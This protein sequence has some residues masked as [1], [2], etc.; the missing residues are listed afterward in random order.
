M[1]VVCSVKKVKLMPIALQNYADSP[2]A[3]ALDCFAVAP[4][5]LD[6]LPKITK[7]L[8]I[9]EAGDVVLR[10]ANAQAD[11]IF[12]NLPVGYMLDVR[13][14]AVRATGTTAASIVGLA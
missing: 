6:L 5:D 14:V 2:T 1:F 12:R 8:Y 7:A 4:H 13:V 10:A 11:V 3:P 9:G